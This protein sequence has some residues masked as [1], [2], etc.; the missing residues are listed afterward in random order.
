MMNGVIVGFGEVARNGHWPAYAVQAGARIVAVVDPTPSR[1]ALAAQ[2]IPGVQTA[3]TIDEIDADVQ[4]VDVCTPP[5]LHQE[6]VLA[7]LDRGWHVLCE[8]PFVLRSALLAPIRD[9]AIA[10]GLAVVPVHNWKYAPILRRATE[11]LRE[12][13]IGP[14][15][16]VDITTT[17]TQAA[18]TVSA[19]DYNWRHD[20]QVAGGGILM[21]HG[22]HA[23]YLALHWFGEAPLGISGDLKRPGGSDVETDVDVQVQ[24]PSGVARIVLTWNGTVRRNAVAFQGE[25]GEIVVDDDCLTVRGARSLTEHFDTALSGGSHHA[26]WFTAMLP[27]VLACFRAPARSRALLDEAEQCIRLIE[28]AY[29]GAS[30]PVP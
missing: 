27:D 13:V 24:F 29:A 12:G 5:S 28:L 11:L 1:R 21:D 8:K 2:V 4:F 9:R 7:A 6:P 25:L 15:R 10:S 16:H 30:V 26:D 17:R 18:A 19:G 20:R 23:L 3:A 14:L 22:W